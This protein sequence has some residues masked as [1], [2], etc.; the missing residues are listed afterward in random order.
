MNGFHFVATPSFR[1]VHKHTLFSIQK[2]ITDFNYV[3]F[4]HKIS[5]NLAK[6]FIKTKIFYQK[7]KIIWVYVTL[8]DTPNEKI[9]IKH[10]KFFVQYND[11]NRSDDVHCNCNFNFNCNCDQLAAEYLIW[12]QIIEV[13]SAEQQTMINVILL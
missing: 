7:G 4:E 3:N 1:I 8:I 12:M 9:K 2:Q 11:T 10:N 5:L 13:I 6:C